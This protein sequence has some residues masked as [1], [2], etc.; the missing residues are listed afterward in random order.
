MFKNHPLPMLFQWLQK[1]KGAVLSKLS[2]YFHD[3]L[4]QQTTPSDM[5][6]LCSKLHH[7]HYQ[8]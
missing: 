3:T 8:K 6:H 7:D 5:R 4:A 2:L 1:L